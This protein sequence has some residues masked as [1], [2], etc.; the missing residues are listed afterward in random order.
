MHPS[1]GGDVVLNR[2]HL[3]SY[4]CDRYHHRLIS[5]WLIHKGPQGPL[6]YCWIPGRRWGGGWGGVIRRYSWRFT[7]AGAPEDG[8]SGGSRWTVGGGRRHSLTNSI[9]SRCAPRSIGQRSA[10]WLSVSVRA[11]PSE[12]CEQRAAGE[13]AALNGNANTNCF[14]IFPYIQA[15]PSRVELALQSDRTRRFSTKAHDLWLDAVQCAFS[16]TGFPG[17]SFAA[18]VRR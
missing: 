7:V 1:D 8:C 13:E 12:A 11:A 6:C 5:A 2:L 10:Q 16:L 18:G 3:H 17:V 9:N 14:N 15:A 4:S